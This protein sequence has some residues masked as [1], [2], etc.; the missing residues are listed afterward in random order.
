MS[1]RKQWAQL[2]AA[3]HRVMMFAGA[4][5][6]VA[7]LLWWAVELGGRY[8]GL[9]SPMTPVVPGAW[10]HGILMLYAVFPF[11][12]LGFLMTT[13]PR[14]M[15]GEP[16]TRSRYVAAF[17]PM[18]AGALLFYPALF[19]S[20]TW[21]AVSA[22]LLLAG[23]LTALWAL[24]DVFR[25][26]PA[27]DK[28]YERILNI[29]LAVAAAG[30]GAWLLWLLTGRHAA[31]AFAL[32]AGLWGFLLPVLVTVA[33][34]M[35]PFFS[36]NALPG[37]TVVQPGWALA[38]L[39]AGLAV[40][41]LLEL[42][43]AQA[44]RVLPDAVLAAT[45]LY[46]SARWGL[47]RSFKVRL[48]AMLH[49]AF[50]W[51]GIGMTLYTIEGVLSLAGAGFSLGKAPLH[52]LGIG[53]IAGMVVAMASRVTL[54]HSGRP[55]VADSFTWACFWGVNLAAVVRILGELPATHMVLG[56]PLN[57]AAAVLWLLA[58]TP[59]AL[60]YGAMLVRPRVDGKPG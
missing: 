5:Q 53:F 20:R 55:L 21:L 32:H 13:Y 12:I 16:I 60:R 37:Y 1:M 43:G 2:S 27:R 11:F 46:L 59:W 6:L 34:R 40:H 26:A 23:W 52:A 10:V 15:G 57:L 14:W 51:F 28:R 50:L 17:L 25:R 3:P 4:F 42:G 58:L 29:A 7:T 39:P 49:V 47:L 56:I 8:T 18:A 9:W 54:G 33:H 38:V 41:L 45:A 30:M 31:L 35:V 48:V 22:A 19:V 24:Y 36:V 44:W